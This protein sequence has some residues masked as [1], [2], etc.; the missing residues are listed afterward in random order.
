[1][2]KKLLATALQALLLAGATSPVY[3]ANQKKPQFNGPF[4]HVLLISIDGMHSLDYQNC[5]TGLP[6]INNGQPYCPNLAAL[7]TTG[8]TYSNASTSQPS[9]S[10]PGVMAVVSGGSPRTVGAFY[11]V[12]FDRYLAPPAKATGNGVAAGPCPPVAPTPK[13]QYSGTTTEY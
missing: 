1:M 4:Q 6:G 7:G 8:T 2:L 12:A 10:F 3:A 11:D 5:A 9:D 13:Y